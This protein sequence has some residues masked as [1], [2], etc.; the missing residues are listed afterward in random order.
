MHAW[1]H[2]QRQLVHTLTTPFM[3]L[4]APPHLAVHPAPGCHAQGSNASAEE[5]VTLQGEGSRMGR[6]RLNECRG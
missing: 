5:V 3:Q 2:R 4:W 6:P 1:A